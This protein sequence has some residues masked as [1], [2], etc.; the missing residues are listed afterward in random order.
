MIFDQI[1]IINN[2]KKPT[3]TAP[4]NP[5]KIVKILVLKLELGLELLELLH[6]LSISGH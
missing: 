5:L 2:N 6:I 1:T 3:N 4:T